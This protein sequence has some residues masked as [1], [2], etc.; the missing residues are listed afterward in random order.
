MMPQWNKYRKSFEEI[1]QEFIIPVSELP[2]GSTPQTWFDLV[3]TQDKI[4]SI[5][6][7]NEKNNAQEKK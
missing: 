1:N 2:G 4:T 3:I 5:H 7:N 6:I